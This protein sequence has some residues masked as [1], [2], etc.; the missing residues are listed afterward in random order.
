MPE[1]AYR[2]SPRVPCEIDASKL[3]QQIGS[4]PVQRL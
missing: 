2:F 4:P 3:S 1:R